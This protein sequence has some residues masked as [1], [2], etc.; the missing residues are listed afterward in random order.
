MPEIKH[1]FTVKVGGMRVPQRHK[2]MEDRE[3]AAAKPRKNSESEKE[4]EMVVS[5]RYFLLIYFFK[6]CILENLK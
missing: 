1:S 3:E 5:K 6:F 2:G 4:E